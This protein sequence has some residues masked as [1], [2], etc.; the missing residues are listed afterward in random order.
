M[1]EK[2][3]IE[4]FPK[5]LP[6]DGASLFRQWVEAHEDIGRD[7]G[8]HLAEVLSS[9]R[10]RE[11]TGPELDRI[12]E[13]F[14]ELGHRRGRGDEEYRAFLM[15]LLPSF[16]GRGTPSGLAFAIGAGV[17]ASADEIEITEHFDDTAYSVTVGDWITHEVT[18]VEHLA[19]L[20]DPAGVSLR[21][22]I[23][24]SYEASGVGI[25]P[26]PGDVERMATVTQPPS[27]VGIQAHDGTVTARSGGFGTRRFD[28]EEEFGSFTALG[29]GVQHSF[30]AAE[31]GDASYGSTDG[32]N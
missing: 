17:Q 23:T 27:G 21:R 31:Y 29:D 30:G 6:R 32:G 19:E 26:T 9:T 16:G 20:A 22:P 14:G 25:D 15:S 13:R 8:E 12:G 28:G 24:Y 7:E 4:L 2:P 1:I 18:T 5:P 3:L 11:A 10:I